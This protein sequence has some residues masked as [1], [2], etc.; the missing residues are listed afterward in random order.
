MAS[1][2]TFTPQERERLAPFVSDLDAPVF[3]LLGL[4]ETTCG[5]LFARYSRY[6]GTLRRLMLDEFG[7][8]LDRRPRHGR[9]GA[10]RSACRGALR[11]GAGRVRR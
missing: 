7:E 3:A 8:D 1:A 11:A 5:A 9:R 10:R 6:P 2:E 4:P